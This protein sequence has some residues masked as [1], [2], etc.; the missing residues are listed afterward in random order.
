MD[1]MTRW[2]LERLAKQ[3]PGYAI[4]IT[5]QFLDGEQGKAAGFVPN[6]WN[7]KAVNINGKWY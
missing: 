2:F 4:R 3:Y 6:N 1:E 7:G 5:H